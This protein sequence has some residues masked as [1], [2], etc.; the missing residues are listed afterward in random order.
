MQSPQDVFDDDSLLTLHWLRA[1]LG[2]GGS[3]TSASQLALRDALSE[4]P[5]PQQRLQAPRD[6]PFAKRTD[7]KIPTMGLGKRSSAYVP[8]FSLG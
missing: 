2:G 3:V 7:G 6:L 8:Y 1:L 5:R 4:R